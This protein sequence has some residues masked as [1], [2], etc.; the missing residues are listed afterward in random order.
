MTPTSSTLSHDSP[1]HLGSPSRPPTSAKTPLPTIPQH[2]PRDPS[3]PLNPAQQSQATPTKVAPPASDTPDRLSEFSRAFP[4]L[5]EFGKQ[6]ED[7]DDR[8]ASLRPQPNGEYPF[9]RDPDSKAP[10]DGLPGVEPVKSGERP[11]DSPEMEFPDIPSF[12]S[13]PSVPNGKPGNGPSQLEE[14]DSVTSPVPDL[15]AL[16]RPA[17]TSNVQTILGNDEDLLSGSPPS[18]P[19]IPNPRPLP[20]PNG[21]VHR[22]NSAPSSSQNHS[23]S[24]QFPIAKPTPLPPPHPSSQPAPATLTKPKFPITNGIEPDTLRSYFLDPAVDMVLLDVRSEEEFG[25]S[26]VGQEYEARGAKVRVVWVDPTVLMR[27]GYV[28]PSSI[29]LQANMSGIV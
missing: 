23:P 7:I 15:G 5:S 13:L 26:H 6:F 24:L 1:A 19:V 11:S 2:P 3:P 29:S 12:P 14:T 22:E 9:A 4:S 20:H 17:S 27:E 16:R 25:R 28:S 8:A 10:I 18:M 21:H